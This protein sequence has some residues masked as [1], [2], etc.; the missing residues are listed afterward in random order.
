MIIENLP[1]E[2]KEFLEAIEE[3]GFSLCLVG[4]A[5]RDFFF[6]KSIGADFDF[7]IRPSANS[8][9]TI[10]QWPNYYLKL[11]DFFKVKNIKFEILPYLITRVHF[12]EKA[13][14]FSSPRI[15]VAIE[16]NY[17]HHHFEAI[18]D[19][20]ISYKSSFL[21]RDLTINAIGIE[22]NFKGSQIE[23][24]VDPYNGVEDLKQKV[25]N[26]ISNDF[27]LDPNRFLRLIR[28]SLKFDSFTV[29]EVLL[30][31]LHR[32]HLTSISNHHFNEELFKSNPSDFLNIFSQIIKKY[33]LEISPTYLFWT[34]FEFPK[35]IKDKDD[36][37][38]FIYSQ[39]KQDAKELMTF[40]S[41][42]E[43]KLN[44]L[45]SFDQSYQKLACLEDKDYLAILDQSIEIALKNP[46]LKDLKNLEDKK[47]WRERYHNF[48]GH[49]KLLVQWS[50]WENIEVSS[51]E[52]FAI[53]STL[54]S[55]YRYYKTLKKIF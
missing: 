4:G 19:P 14:E 46:I 17:T 43:K 35:T 41:M 10:T 40:F 33:N 9:V 7:E 2:I 1:L 3:L 8:K 55:Y 34:K 36:L 15:E 38:V 21:R 44:E 23:S 45:K 54:R 47:Q 29:S 5:P 37:L 39:N 22:F 18:L 48:F 16:D 6:N 25:L 11:H 32:F 42:P 30:N 12:L 13:F 24:L 52:L 50:D 26:I 27:F 31:Q 51:V 28:L 53:E 20:N 49:N